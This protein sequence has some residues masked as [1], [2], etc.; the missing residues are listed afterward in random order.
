MELLDFAL[1]RYDVSL[2]AAIAALVVFL[3]LTLLHVWRIYRHRSFYFTAFTI[4][5]V[6]TWWPPH[7]KP[8]PYRP[9]DH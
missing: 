3:I 7:T 5:G 1:Y 2:P 6:C 4:G 9:V 8:C